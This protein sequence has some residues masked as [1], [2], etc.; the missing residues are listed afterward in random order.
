MVWFNRTYQSPLEFLKT[1]LIT[2]SEMRTL[3]DGA[4]EWTV[5]D[6]GNKVSA[7]HLIRWL[8]V[9]C[10]NYVYCN[11]PNHYKTILR[12]DTQQK[13]AINSKIN[14]KKCLNYHKEGSKKEARTRETKRNSEQNATPK[15]NKTN[16]IKSGLKPSIKRS[17]SDLDLISLLFTR[18]S[19]LCQT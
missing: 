16:F 6:N 10:K 11:P 2:G 19:L 15:F 8:E 9:D 12:E 18:I 13:N 17:F 4:C 1:C 5:P 14:I 3:W 7:S